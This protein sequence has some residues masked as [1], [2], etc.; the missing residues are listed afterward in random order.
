MH[1]LDAFHSFIS[2]GAQKTSAHIGE[3]RA[4]IVSLGG[5]IFLAIC[6]SLTVVLMIVA[7]RPSLAPS[8]WILAL[9]LTV[10]SWVYLIDSLTERLRLLDGCVEYD[11]LLTRR[12]LIPIAGL[13]EILFVDEGFNLERGMISIEFRRGGAQSERIALGPCWQRN[14][15][16]RFLRAVELAAQKPKVGEAVP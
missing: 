15:L 11:S 3:A 9:L 12:R 1:I 4:E 13:H 8:Q 7:Q 16:E 6:M 10:G 14:K 2:H 5:A